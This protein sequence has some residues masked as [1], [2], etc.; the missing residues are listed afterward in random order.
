[1][2]CIFLVITS[3]QDGDTFWYSFF[4]TVAKQYYDF[5]VEGSG[6]DERVILARVFPENEVYFDEDSQLCG[7]DIIE[8][9]FPEED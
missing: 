9:K 2:K 8:E 6:D 1:M 4:E 5:S 7:A 3:N